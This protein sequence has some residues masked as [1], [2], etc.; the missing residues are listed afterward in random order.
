VVVLTAGHYLTIIASEGRGVDV[1]A[2]PIR[3]VG[4][5]GCAASNIEIVKQDLFVVTESLGSDVTAEGK[6]LRRGWDLS[7][8]LASCLYDAGAPHTVWRRWS[9]LAAFGM[10]LSGE[11]VTSYPYLILAGEWSCIDA[12]A[13]RP[14]SRPGSVGLRAI[15]M[16]AT[17]QRDRGEAFGPVD[18][19]DSPWLTLCDS[20]PEDD[21]SRTEEALRSLADF[22]I[23]EDEEWDTFHPRSFPSFEPEVCAAAALAKRR[24]YAPRNLPDDALRF[25]DP[26][27]A[28][29]WPEPL[30]PRFSPSL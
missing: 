12:M 1:P 23:L 15:W 28:D 6:A 9:A 26:G 21:F 19:S 17:G 10:V 25:L 4:A 3:R 7:L 2:G 27:L 22:W 24:G 18:D 29:G 14:V 13:D 30:Y 5:G 16:L 11:Y 20:I 8:E